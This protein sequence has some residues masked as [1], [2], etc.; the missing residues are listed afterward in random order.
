MSGSAVGLFLSGAGTLVVG[1]Q[2][3]PATG[4]VRMYV[5]HRAD[6]IYALVE[7][8]EAKTELRQAW[9]NNGQH[10]VVERPPDNVLYTEAERP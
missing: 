9:A 4:C 8:E 6:G 7:D 3:D 2:E 5:G 10:L 1:V